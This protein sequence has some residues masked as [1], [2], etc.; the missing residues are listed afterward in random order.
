MLYKTA[1]CYDTFVLNTVAWSFDH[2][3]I[4]VCVWANFILAFTLPSALAAWDE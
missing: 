1:D 3:T 2:S 4:A